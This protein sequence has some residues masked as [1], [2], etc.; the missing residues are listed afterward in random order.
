MTTDIEF[1]TKEE[2]TAAWE[3]LQ[4]EGSCTEVFVNNGYCIE[5]KPFEVML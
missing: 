4:T 5:F 2:F 1:T 3:T